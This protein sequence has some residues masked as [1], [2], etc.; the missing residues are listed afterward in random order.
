MMHNDLGCCNNGHRENI[1]YPTHNMVS[2]GIS[3]NETSE[4]VFFVED[5]ENLYLNYHVSFSN[6]IVT[7]QGN[8]T[9]PLDLTPWRSSL[10]SFGF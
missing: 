9:Q 1:L 8:M 10:Q 6:N 3:Y 2:I 5:F 7:L 4:M